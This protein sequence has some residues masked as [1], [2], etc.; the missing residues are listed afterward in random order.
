MVEGKKTAVL[1]M[2]E[3]MGF[4]LPDWLVF[5]VGDGCTIAGAWKALQDS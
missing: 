2:A 3:Q 1:E 5:S 4:D